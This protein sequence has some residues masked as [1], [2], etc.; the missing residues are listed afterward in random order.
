[1]ILDPNGMP[2]LQ[3]TVDNAETATFNDAFAAIGNALA[4]VSPA[5]NVSATARAS[6]PDGWLL[7]DGSAVSRTTYEVLFTAISTTYGA[8]NGSTTFN[9]P[10]L[11]GRMPVGVDSGQTEFNTLGETGG[12]KTHSHTLASAWAAL[13]VTAGYIRQNRRGGVSWSGNI[14]GNTSPES[15]SGSESYGTNLGGQTDDSSTLPPYIA[16]NYIVKT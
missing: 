4:G 14:R 7:C 2:I 16:L 6:A 9:V 1:M 3:P 12:A 10:N 8:G 15:Y 11:K 13:S 5:G